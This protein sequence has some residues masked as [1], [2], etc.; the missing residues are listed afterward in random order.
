MLPVIDLRGSARDPAGLLPR[1][2]AADLAAARASVRALVEDV[3]ERGD[4]A[5]AEA[6]WRFDGVDTPPAAWRATAAELAAAEAA[7]DPELRT[8]LLDAIERVRAF[9]RA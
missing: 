5:V 7:L 8:A 9:H 6:A 4:H 3:A 1:A 2:P